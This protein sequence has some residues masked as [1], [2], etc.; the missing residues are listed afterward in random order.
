MAYA[1]TRR[2]DRFP[3]CGLTP[4]PPSSVLRLLICFLGLVALTVAPVH[5]QKKG[6]EPE[7]P[8]A[9]P[10]AVSRTVTVRPEESVQIPLGIHGV[11]GGQIEFLVRSRP[12][13][14]VLSAVKTIGLNSAV[15]QYTAGPETGDDQFTYAVRTEEGVSAP[16]VVTI[17]VIVAPQL[18]SRLVTVEEIHFPEVIAGQR[19]SSTLVVTNKGGGLATGDVTVSP[20][21]QIEGGSHYDLTSGKQTEFKIVFAPGAAGDFTGSATLGPSP[22]HGLALSG[23]ARSPLEITPA[24][25]ELAALPGNAT[26]TGKFRVENRTAEPRV[27]TISAGPRLL[28]DAS[29]KVAASSAVEVPVFA[30]ADNP[31]GLDEKLALESGSWKVEVAVRAGA[32]PARVKFVTTKLDFGKVAAG[33]SAQAIAILE[34]SGGLPAMVSMRVDAPFELAAAGLEVPALGS[35]KVPVLWLDPK[36]GDYAATLVAEVGG[37]KESLAFAASVARPALPPTAP[38]APDRAERPFNLKPQPVKPSEASAAGSERG[39]S[40]DFMASATVAES[41]GALGQYSRD[42]TSHSAVLEWPSS[43]SPGHSFALFERSI[44]LKPEGGVAILWSPASNVR[45]SEAAGKRIAEIKGLEPAH[46]YVFRVTDSGVAVLTAKFFTL[47]AKPIVSLQT[48]LIT[49]LLGAFGAVAWW[50]FK[51]RTRSGW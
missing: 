11:R 47:E 36:P 23:V 48:I 33:E 50:K 34:N 37:V 6:K 49:L 42:L 16:A 12:K 1:A 22:R 19:S 25:V 5:A 4:G 45:F 2:E 10:P 46:L 18:P 3:N 15:V 9:P 41:A 14:G 40:F 51:N 43:M 29:V 24:A 7:L 35:T 32:F 27:V 13:A 21:W 31:A 30:G 39:S 26:R 8:A 28:V 17:K 44:A 20:P 38:S